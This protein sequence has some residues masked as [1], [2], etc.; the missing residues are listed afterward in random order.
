MK[1]KNDWLMYFLTV[2][3]M[4]FWG[5]SF[6]WVKI[7]YR[8]YHPFT[9]VFLRLFFSSILIFA[10][11]RLFRS[12][13]KVERKD[14]PWLLLLAF[15]EPFL[16]FLGESLG[17]SFVSATVASLII[18]T[19]P[20]FVPVLAYLFLSEKIKPAG[21]IGLSFST[22]GVILLILDRNLQFRYSVKGVLLMYVAVMSAA[23]YT[24]LAARMVRKYRPL[25]LLKF[26]NMLGCLYFLP[27][28]LI[29]GLDNFL[30]VNP[31]PEL[32]TN[33]TLLIVF[34]STLS[35]LFFNMALQSIGVNRA[36]VFT[37][38][39]PLFSAMASNLLLGEPFDMSKIF[40]MIVVICGVGISQYDS[41]RTS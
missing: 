1:P 38:L 19:I 30:S 17:I 12:V 41:S 39:I 32:V 28:F 25:T 10:L 9:V 8:Y 15:F 6:V 7:V 27:L 18:S 34:P 14:L 2:L 11:E 33:L 24:I 26:Q 20:V 31:C 29:F 4:L 16:Y 21:I 3:C 35:F 36:N 37:Y 22:L 40:A 23:G 5:L 13:E